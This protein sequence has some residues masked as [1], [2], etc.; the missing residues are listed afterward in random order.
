[1][2]MVELPLQPNKQHVLPVVK[3]VSVVFKIKA[4]KCIQLITCKVV[5]FLQTNKM[6][7]IYWLENSGGYMRDKTSGIIKRNESSYPLKNAFVKENTT[8]FLHMHFVTHFCLNFH[9]AIA[10][11]SY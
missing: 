11:F 7:L 5:N 9:Y 2:V 1:M 8:A 4:L 10:A 3:R 6:I